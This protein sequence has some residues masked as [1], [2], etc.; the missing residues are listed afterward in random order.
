MAK[1]SSQNL[2][3]I[4]IIINIIIILL[5]NKILRTEEKSRKGKLRDT[6]FKQGER[7]NISSNYKDDLLEIKNEL[8]ITLIIKNIE[9]IKNVFNKIKENQI[10][11]RK[12]NI[13]VINLIIKNDI[14][15]ILI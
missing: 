5:K 1:Y 10:K 6:I 8:I 2:E 4:T 11:K 3:Y 9:A 15:I 12:S 7:L 13:G 14:I